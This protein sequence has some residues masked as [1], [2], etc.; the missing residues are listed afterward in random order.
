MKCELRLPDGA[1][2]ADVLAMTPESPEPVKLDVRIESGRA[3]FTV[4]GFLVYSVVR[5][6]LAE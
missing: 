1:K 6:K 5:L 2:I 3:Q 4:P